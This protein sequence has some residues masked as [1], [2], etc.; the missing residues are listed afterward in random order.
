MLHLPSE[1]KQQL[2]VAAM[3]KGG[4]RRLDEKTGVPPVFVLLAP[5]LFKVTCFIYWALSMIFT[6]KIFILP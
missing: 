2:D 1:Y 5:P 3:I 4:L 6:S